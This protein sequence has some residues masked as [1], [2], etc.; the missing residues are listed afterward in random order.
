MRIVLLGAP[1]SGKGTQAKRLMA[2]LG[3]PHISTGDMLRAAVKADTE[4]GRQAKAVMDRGEL[5]CDELVLGLLRE[6]LQQ[7]D[8]AGGFILD[9]YPRNIVQAKAL[10]Q[11]LDNLEQPID[12]TIEIEIPQQ[13]I[14]D[15]LARRAE[16]ESRTD[17][18]VET[19]RHRLNIYQ[20]QTTPVIDFYTERGT[21]TQVDGVGSIEEV[22]ERIVSI[23]K[24]P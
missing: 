14:I 18:T 2:G 23:F 11:L 22:S 10:D 15:R 7:G 13:Y 5:V 3:V 16:Q 21:L 12:E 8:A 6:R 20:Q 19:V 24:R 17:D 9:G 1:G 4:L